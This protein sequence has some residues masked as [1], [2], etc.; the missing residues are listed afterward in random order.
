MHG[1]DLLT[2]KAACVAHWRSLGAIAQCHHAKLGL[3]ILAG[4]TAMLFSM[5]AQ[6]PGQQPMPDAVRGER[7]F[8]ENCAACHN[9]SR[10]AG[11]D[12]FADCGY[13]VGA[14]V[15]PQAMGMLLQKP[16]RTKRPDSSMPVYTPEELSDADLFDMG[17]YLASQTPVPAEPANC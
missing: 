2:F 16:V 14:G 11:P 1:F 4:I 17:F 15:P 9:H 8:L 13:F 6:Q 12:M 10:K 3:M 7:L 5:A